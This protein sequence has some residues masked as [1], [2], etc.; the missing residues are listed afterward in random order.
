MTIFY[1]NNIF[2]LLLNELLYN[3]KILIL[4]R[5]INLFKIIFSF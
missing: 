1:L 2:V 5:L 4:N 3:I